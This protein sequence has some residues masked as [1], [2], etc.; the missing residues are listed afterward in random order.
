MNDDIIFKAKYL[1]YKKKYLTL[2]YTQFGGGNYDRL[3]WQ[4]I[5]SIQGS[6]PIN[7]PQD[8]NKAINDLLVDNIKTTLTTLDTNQDTTFN[9]EIDL[10]N[11]TVTL[12]EIGKKDKYTFTFYYNKQLRRFELEIEYSLKIYNKFSKLGSMNRS[13]NNGVTPIN[14]DYVKAHNKLIIFIPYINERISHLS[15]DNLNEQEIK[16]ENKNYIHIIDLFNRT[17]QST[18]NGAFAGNGTISFVPPRPNTPHP[19]HLLP[20][21]P[22]ALQAAAAKP[23]ARA[24]SQVPPRPP[25]AFARPVPSAPAPSAPSP[26]PTRPAARAASPVAAAPLAAAA[27]ASPPG[28]RYYHEKFNGIMNN[29]N[30]NLYGC[31]ITHELKHPYV[32][33]YLSGYLVVNFNKQEF[34]FQFIYDKILSKQYDKITE[35]LKQ[36][37]EGFNLMNFGELSTFYTRNKITPQ[38]LSFVDS[39]I[40]TELINSANN[41]AFFMLPSQFN[42]AE[43]PSPSRIITDINDYKYDPTGGPIGQL[44]CNPVVAQF[45]LDNAANQ[46][47]VRKGY[48]INYLDEFI[49]TVNKLQPKFKFELKNGY[50]QWPPLDTSEIPDD[51]RVNLIQ[52]M[53]EHF[54]KIKV[55]GTLDI[56]VDG[57]HGNH[58]RYP[59]HRVSLFYGSAVPLNGEYG[60]GYRSSTDTPL[61][62]FI[63]NFFMIS[64]YFGILKIALIK[65][66]A[67]EKK[68]KVFLMPLGGGVFKNSRFNIINNILFSIYLLKVLFAIDDINTYLHIILLTY[69]GIDEHKHFKILHE[70]LLGQSQDQQHRTEVVHSLPTLKIFNDNDHIKL[71]TAKSGYIFYMVPIEM[72][73]ALI[74]INNIGV[75]HRRHN[76][77]IIEKLQDCIL[78]K[79][80]IGFF[81]SNNRVID[82]KYY[83]YLDIADIK[84]RSL[85]QLYYKAK[86]NTQNQEFIINQDYTLSPKYK[87]THKLVLNKFGYLIHTTK[88]REGDEIVTV[89]RI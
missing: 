44:T 58:K 63:A 83:P 70:Q 42:G 9:C 78:L 59:N 88:L 18:H 14:I 85:L 75:E 66:L 39:D 29:S 3:R 86:N 55:F 60:G 57:T 46:F 19:R 54:D 35:Q 31:L 52:N 71:K 7:Y 15:F 76:I 41:G 11:N 22:S 47:T 53:I 72:R 25:T 10:I 73:A 37:V 4:F 24:A 43:Y 79:T 21:K 87:S 38:N 20:H 64:Q 27:P 34:K 65:A 81:Y 36:H 32:Y 23:P 2:K 62:I 89:E 50:L 82:G 69:N 33:K 56:T 17:Y 45:I 80:I 51:E 1:K 84:D 5:S 40:T 13:M 61:D 26:A 30:R 16:I 77:F 12:T 8:V 28:N 6:K 74:K 49:I 67:F 48:G 68:Q